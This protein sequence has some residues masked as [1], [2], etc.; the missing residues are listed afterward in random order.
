MENL[1]EEIETI[2]VENGKSIKDIL[3]AG[4]E[5]YG[6]IPLDRFFKIA[7]ETN[8]SAGFGGT[9]VAEDLKVVGDS[10]WLE[11]DRYDGSEWWEFKTM[12]I[13]PK[14]KDARTLSSDGFQYTLRDMNSLDKY[15]RMD[16]EG[17]ELKEIRAWNKYVD[18]DSE[19]P[20]EDYQNSNGLD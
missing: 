14:T 20:F 16:Y 5:D 3:W 7:K 18:S 15:A 11:R 17:D 19:L 9:E 1:Y 2:L 8:Y 4:A 6:V 10:W 13:K 12:P